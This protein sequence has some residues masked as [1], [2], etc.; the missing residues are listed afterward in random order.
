MT[1][2]ELIDEHVS[3][4]QCQLAVEALLKHEQRRQEK[5]QESQLLPGKEQ[6]VWLVLTTKQ[7][8]PE[9]KLKPH[10]IPIM[11]PLV[12]PRTSGVCLITKDP[13]REYKDLL[14]EHKIKF[15][16]RVVGIEKLKGKWK[17]FEARRL[18]LKENDLF[19]ADERVVPLLPKLLGKKF[20]DAK[21]QPIPVNL[22]R[23]DLK[24]ELER[25]I[26][27]TYFH[28]NQGTCSSIKVGTLS[29]TPAQVLANLQ[30]AL[31]AIVKAIK[32]G[33][34]NIQSFHIKT[35]TSSSLPIWSCDL[36]SE[37]GGRWAGLADIA[38]AEQE[39]DE[40]SDKEKSEEETVRMTTRSKK[41]EKGKKRA[42]EE[43]SEEKPN[44]KSKKRAVEDDSEEKPK[45]KKKTKAAVVSETTPAST[46]IPPP[47]PPPPSTPADGLGQ[48]PTN[49]K[50]KRKNKKSEVEPTVV[51]GAIEK[52][53]VTEE[54]PRAVVP[55]SSD[56]VGDVAKDVD[57]T[58]PA[59]KA[60]HKKNKAS[61]GGDASAVPAPKD[62]ELTV[63]EK[64]LATV[65]AEEVCAPE[66][67]EKKKKRKKKA[68]ES[69]D[70]D[71]AASAPATVTVDE[72]KQK[73]GA[74][75]VEKK[76]EK[77]VKAGKR[78]AKDGVLGKKG[79]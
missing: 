13:Q 78:S 32:G 66:D 70:V 61:V 63:A 56:P 41:S 29:Q 74:S 20:F 46:R 53:A 40:G 11:H 52:L 55:S 51:I 25:A 27:S 14:E 77:A 37:N 57:G 65:P 7:M 62:T 72:V 9:K 64:T 26:S 39:D 73:R 68:Q 28:Q 79:V 19:L 17:P 60:R 48:T 71:V 4:S 67:G 69:S 44:E 8:H 30:S 54:A 3:S 75:G 5:L 2:A 45:K 42:A 35:N 21:K 24:G 59:R 76:K 10:K 34:D 16:S 38:V 36:G 49:P 12:D 47:P 22:T 23:K 58:K 6:N 50:K 15:V 1:Q 18:L 31:P 43:V 33:W